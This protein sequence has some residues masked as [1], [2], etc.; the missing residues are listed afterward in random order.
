MGRSRAEIRQAWNRQEP[1]EGNLSGTEK[2][3]GQQQVSPLWLAGRA[4][5]GLGTGGE[6]RV[7]L[8]SGGWWVWNSEEPLG[9]RENECLVSISGVQPGG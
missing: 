1:G 5:E 8:G 4:G 2:A 9:A 6:S 7:N 3:Q